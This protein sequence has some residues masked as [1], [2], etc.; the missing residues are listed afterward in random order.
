VRSTGAVIRGRWGG[1]DCPACIGAYGD[2]TLERTQEALLHSERWH[3]AV[4]RR[5][6]PRASSVHDTEGTD[7]REQPVARAILGL[8]VDELTGKTSVDPEWQSV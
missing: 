6:L 2:S 7:R 4:L 3:E 8:E 1:P 5:P